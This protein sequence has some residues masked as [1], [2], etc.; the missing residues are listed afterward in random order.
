M[1]APQLKFHLCSH[2]CTVQICGVHEP[3]SWIIC[4]QPTTAAALFDA[5][6]AV[7]WAGVIDDHFW[8]L[9]SQPFKAVQ[10]RHSSARMAQSCALLVDKQRGITGG[11]VTAA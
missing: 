3:C 9:Y 6:Y 2:V 8:L 11:I 1:H 5:G 10:Q 7:S 4:C